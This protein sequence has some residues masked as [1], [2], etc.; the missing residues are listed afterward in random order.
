MKR[1]FAYLF[2]FL[3]SYNLAGYLVVF[4]VRQNIVRSEIKK[5]LKESVPHSDLILLTFH[6]TS[7]QQGKY[8]LQWIENHEFRYAGGMYD[9]VHSRTSADST[10]YLCVND[11]QEEALFADLDSHV[12]R[13]M[14]SQGARLDAFKDAFKNSFT[15]RFPDLPVL[16][17]IATNG[18]PIQTLYESVVADVASPPPRLQSPT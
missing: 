6:T 15:D 8:P 1:T 9:I 14:G 7:L 16:T 3:Y 12:Q 11:V 18:P 17:V 13:E 2:L 4:S 10:H 5:M